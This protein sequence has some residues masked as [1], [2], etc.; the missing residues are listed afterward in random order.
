MGFVV[1]AILNLAFQP[2]AMA[3]D[4]DKD[5]PCPHC[6]GEVGQQQQHRD[7]PL[8]LTADCELGDDYSYDSRTSKSKDDEQPIDVPAVLFEEF[9]PSEAYRSHSG[10]SRL[11]SAADL[12]N[13][14][15]LITLYC[16][17]LK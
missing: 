3:M 9:S 12:S 14:P 1:V 7:A 6:P 13:G 4:M 16:V 10:C 8:N 17:Y 2:C 11:L 5:R 15:P